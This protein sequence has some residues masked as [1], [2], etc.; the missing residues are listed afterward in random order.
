MIHSYIYL[1]NFSKISVLSYYLS[2]SKNVVAD[3]SIQ[4]VYFFR[5]KSLSLNLLI[6]WKRSLRDEVFLTS[7]QMPIYRHRSRRN[8]VLLVKNPREKHET[9]RSLPLSS[10]W[11]RS[12]YE[13]RCFM[14]ADHIQRIF[15]VAFVHW[16]AMEQL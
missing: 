14:R 8:S 9:I 3:F 4:R 5:T 13:R 7:F 11:N 10:I 1:N 15:F 16:T 6:L 2:F 12:K